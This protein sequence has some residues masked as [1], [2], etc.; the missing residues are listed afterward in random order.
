MRADRVADDASV[1]SR[2]LRH[3]LVALAAVFVLLG[4]TA[5]LLL[6]SV[7]AMAAGNPTLDK[8]IISDPEAGWSDLSPTE[9]SGLA[10]S[11]ETELES[12]AIAG[13]TFSTAVEGWQSPEGAST[14]ILVIF[15]VQATTGNLDSTATSVASNFCSG[16]TETT[17]ASTPAIPNISSSAVATCSGNSVNA[18]IAVA[19]KGS[20]LTMV[21]ST[22]S[23]V[24]GVSS[25][26]PVVASQL[27]ALPG[28]STSTGSTSGSSSSS[29]IVGGI[30]LVVLV[31][32]IVIATVLLMRR[33][34]SRLAAAGTA[35]GV[36]PMGGPGFY[37]PEQ[38]GAPPAGVQAQQA[39][40]PYVVPGAATSDDPWSGGGDPGWVSPLGA[41]PPP[42]APSDAGAVSAPGWYP[43]GGDN[44]VMRYWDGTKFTG[45][46][47]WDGTAWVEA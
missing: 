46:R 45:R 27:N 16:A 30:V 15:L 28:S 26:E 32:L 31:A 34:Q 24:L 17:P 18:S 12:K 21:A 25:L 9:T 29:A 8:L 20:I 11:I 39:P 35:G 41:P 10:T 40:S 47:R 7:P 44:S 19:I 36:Q 2:G 13:Q 37:P 6:D 42:A 1:K 14:S 43:E 3:I 23:Q 33:R 38:P 5:G 4:T 22:G